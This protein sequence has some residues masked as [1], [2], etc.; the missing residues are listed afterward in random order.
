MTVFRKQNTSD[1]NTNQ[2]RV[3]RVESAEVFNNG[4][5]RLRLDRKSVV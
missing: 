5:Q 3:R 4:F 2:S 1:E